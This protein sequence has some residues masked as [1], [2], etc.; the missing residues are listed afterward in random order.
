[1]R[2]LPESLGLGERRC[3][4]CG[5]PFFAK[6]DPEFIAPALLC[7]ACQKLLQLYRGPAC[8]LCGL[9]SVAA[10]EN[11]PKYGLKRGLCASC[12]QSAPPWDKIA[13]YG[14]YSSELRDL[15]LRLK[16]D[17]ALHIA[18]LL[19]EFLREACQCLPQPDAIVAIPQY[20]ERLRSRGYNQAH[21]LAKQLGVLTGL[22]VKTDIL[23]R[24]LPGVPQ[25]ELNAR[26]RIEN[27]RHAFMASPQ[28]AGM[29]IWLVDDVLT[30]GST[31]SAGT[32]ALKMAGAKAVYPLFVART[33]LELQM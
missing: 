1:M 21:E 30:T 10:L 2:Q 27:M 20:P 4:N 15:I 7:Q 5:A 33:P 11:S 28:V 24:V 22:P 3:A 14:L 23:Q 29:S 25:E 12:S 16:F 18:R 19:A 9:P 32:C 17:G 13:F 6:D 26:Q 31:C 8:S